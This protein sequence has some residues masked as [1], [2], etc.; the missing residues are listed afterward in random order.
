MFLGDE[1]EMP[2]EWL[3]LEHW[4]RV[5]DDAGEPM[6]WPEDLKPDGPAM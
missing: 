3:W 2:K 4:R 5:L 1:G 6:P